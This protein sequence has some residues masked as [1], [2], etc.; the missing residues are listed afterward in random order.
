MQQLNDRPLKSGVSMEISV[1]EV[2]PTGVLAF[3]QV[4]DPTAWTQHNCVAAAGV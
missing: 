4:L 3:G 1:P 2:M